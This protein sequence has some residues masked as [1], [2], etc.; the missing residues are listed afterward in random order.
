MR[1]DLE[2]KEFTRSALRIGEGKSSVC[3]ER[4]GRALTRELV[5]YDLY[6]LIERISVNVRILVCNTVPRNIH[7]DGGRRGEYVNALRCGYLLGLLAA[8]ALQ[9]IL[10]KISGL[11]SGSYKAEL[12]RNCSAGVQ[13]NVAEIGV[14]L[15][16]SNLI[17]YVHARNSV[18]GARRAGCHG[19]VK[20]VLDLFTLCKF[21]RTLKRIA[22]AYVCYLE[23][24]VLIKRGN[25]VHIDGKIVKIILTV[26]RRNISYGSIV[27][28][29]NYFRH[30][31][32]NG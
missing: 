25:A 14:V 11:V 9:V 32:D 31:N 18:N 21:A 27:Q 8:D 30:I 13:T 15:I 4:N 23:R 19:I 7:I 26:R 5:A 29:S 10:Y 28:R 17:I 24:L 16:R 2:Y 12:M 20:Y 1:S 3:S 6:S 22:E